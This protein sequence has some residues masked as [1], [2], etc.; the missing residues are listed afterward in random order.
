MKSVV[1]II[2]LLLMMIDEPYGQ[3]GVSKQPD[4]MLNVIQRADQAFSFSELS[5]IIN[6]CS[7]HCNR[8]AEISRA[9]TEWLRESNNIYTGKSSSQSNQFRVFLL[10]SLSRFKPN[11][12]L[13]R[14]IKYELQ[15]ADYGYNIAAAAY[16]ARN[17]ESKAAELIGLFEPFLR[18]SFRDEYV[19]I[20]TYSPDYPLSNPTR[21]RYEI[22]E[23]LVKFGPSSYGAVQMISDLKDYLINNTGYNDSTLY[24]KCDDA[25]KYINEATPPCCRKEHEIVQPQKQPQYTRQAVSTNSLSLIDQEGKKTKFRNISGKPFVLTFF[26]TRCTNPL[27]CMATVNRLAKLQQE[28]ID[29]QLINKVGI[30]GMTFDP[31]F[32]KPSIIKNYG[33][34]YGMKFSDNVRFFLAENGSATDFTSQLQVRVNY[35][36]GSVNQHGSQL[37]VFDKKGKLSN[38]YDNEKWTVDEIS[39]YLNNLARE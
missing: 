21:V 10:Y 33:E 28:L 1:I 7:I 27:K 14:Y 3:A 32:D 39:N 26:Y 38:T 30:Y 23:T 15:F 9:L 25:I 35:G 31:D 5:A 17:F 16:T 2:S 11:D 4:S 37:F 18:S 20:T 34:L 6:F 19:D 8:S 24:A 29:R 12:E 22:L 13:Y 36:Y